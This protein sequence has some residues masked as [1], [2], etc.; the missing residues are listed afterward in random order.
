MMELVGK[1]VLLTVFVE[2][3]L[4]AVVAQTI[5]RQVEPLKIEELVERFV[6]IEQVEPV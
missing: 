5:E 1:I 2:L 4:V 3:L 6:C